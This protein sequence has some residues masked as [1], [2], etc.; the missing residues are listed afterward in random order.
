MWARRGVS[1]LQCPKSVITAKSLYFLEQFRW[2]KQL[3]G[4]DPA[5]MD[6]KTAD[7]IGVLEQALSEENEN[8]EIQE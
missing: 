3:G 8:G 5:S 7:A 6:A 4:W 2:W 1:S